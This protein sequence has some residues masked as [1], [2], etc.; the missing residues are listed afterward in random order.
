MFPVVTGSFREGNGLSYERDSSDHLGMIQGYQQVCNQ[1]KDIPRW[2]GS[3]S[4]N[5][6]WIVTLT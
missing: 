6:Y 5:C 4:Y 3:G 2:P 1:D